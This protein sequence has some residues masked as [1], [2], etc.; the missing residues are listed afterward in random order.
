[1][2]E[3]YD[4]T[5]VLLEKYFPELG[6]N[7][8]DAYVDA[9]ILAAFENESETLAIK[10]YPCILVCPFGKHGLSTVDGVVCAEEKAPNVARA[11]K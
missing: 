10:K 5:D 1:M 8:C 3:L 2:G 4:Y 7:G 6:Q 11:H 9:Y